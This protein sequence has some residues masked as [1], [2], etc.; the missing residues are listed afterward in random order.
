MIWCCKSE[1]FTGPVHVIF[2]QLE[3]KVNFRSDLTLGENSWK[4]HPNIFYEI[5]TLVICLVIKW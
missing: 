5:T 2:R 3:N 4:I 1:I